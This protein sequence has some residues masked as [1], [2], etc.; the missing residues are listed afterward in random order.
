M[1][2]VK[3]AIAAVAL[4]SASA[5]LAENLNLYGVTVDNTVMYFDSDTIRRV[6]GGYINVW[7]LYDGS[8]DRTVRWRTKR[9]LQQIDCNGMMLGVRSFA[10]YDANGRV[11][12][13]GSWYPIMEPVI[14]GSVGYDLV[15]AVCARQ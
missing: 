1:K 11:L 8:R 5:A 13:S 6:S 3:V 7:V 2:A 4:T 10:E 14:P 12:D 15:E 9:V